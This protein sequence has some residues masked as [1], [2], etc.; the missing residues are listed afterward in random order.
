MGLGRAAVP[1]PS[2]LSVPAC[3][4]VC[5]AWAPAW[6]SA[7]AP[8]VSGSAASTR[9]FRV[10][11]EPRAAAL[12]A[13]GLIGWSGSRNRTV[14]WEWYRQGSPG[15]ANM[16]APNL[17]PADS[18]YLQS[19]HTGTLKA[20]YTQAYIAMQSTGQRVP[21][22]QANSTETHSVSTSVGWQ[23]TQSTGQRVPVASEK[24][25]NGFF[26]THGHR[27]PCRAEDSECRHRHMTTQ[28]TC[29]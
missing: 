8:V 7:V 13:M 27:Q 12:S 19:K 6:P 21:A 3:A 29:M 2:L 17:G 10:E 9:C 16:S 4:P 22:K 1:A 5:P 20:R 18:A 25:S 28:N 24:H 15:Y 14:N 23:A 26:S 11:C